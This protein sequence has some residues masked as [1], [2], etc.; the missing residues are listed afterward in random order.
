MNVAHTN[1]NKLI[2]GYPFNMTFCSVCI[3]GTL[4]F[5]FEF[6]CYSPLAVRAEKNSFFTHF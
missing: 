1:R 6:E 3:P 2:L 5:D 4:K